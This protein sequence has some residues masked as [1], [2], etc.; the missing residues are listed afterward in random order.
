MIISSKQISKKL[1]YACFHES[2]FT[3]FDIHL[4]EHQILLDTNKLNYY[5]SIIDKNNL[6]LS[7]DSENYDNISISITSDGSVPIKEIK[8]EFKLLDISSNCEIYPIEFHTDIVVRINCHKFHKAIEELSKYSHNINITCTKTEFIL[9]CRDINH[10]THKR[11][12]STD[13]MYEY[14]DDICIKHIS[15]NE[16]DKTDI[17]I[18]YNF[19]IEEISRFK[20]CNI[21]CRDIDIYFYNKELI[22][23]LKYSNR[24]CNFSIGL[25]SQKEGI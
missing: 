23:F 6:L 4:T 25:K 10:I 14:N 19:N 5:L 7:M 17:P 13:G 3:K 24:I 2:A 21:F 15:M 8:S 12:F 16:T 18:G 20:K 22:M 9:M 1:L 11:I